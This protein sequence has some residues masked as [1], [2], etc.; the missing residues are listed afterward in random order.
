MKDLLDSHYELLAQFL[1]KC[2]RPL[3]VVSTLPKKDREAVVKFLKELGVPVYLEA[4]SGIRENTALEELKISYI[5]RLWEI[6]LNAGYPIDAVLRIGGVP[7]FRPWRDLEDENKKIPVLSVSHLPFTGLSSGSVIHVNLS[8]FFNGFC[9]HIPHHFPRGKEW[10]EQDKYFQK[11]LEEVIEEEPL[12]EP[13]IIR[14]LGETIAESSLVYL[15]NS[16]PIREWDLAA[17]YHNRALDIF[18][19]RGQNGIDGQ[20]STFYGMA[21]PGRENWGIFGDLTMLYDFPASWVLSQMQETKIHVVV[22]NNSGGKIFKGMFP[23]QEIQ[24]CHNLNFEHFAKHWGL[25]Y[26]RS[27]RLPIERSLS[28]AAFYELIPSEDATQR[29]WKRYQAI[30]NSISHKALQPNY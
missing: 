1:S 19:S 20:V 13:S 18:A 15:G 11:L 26:H 27:S 28:Q 2:Q 12:A 23:Y 3:V 22:I 8:D 9:S 7:T 21:T 4:I 25:E 29:F 16:L 30:G 24:N 10:V 14:H 6:S 17:P 5:Y